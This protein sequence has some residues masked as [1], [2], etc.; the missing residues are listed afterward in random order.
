[1]DTLSLTDSSPEV[2]QCGSDR[3][4]YDRYHYSLRFYLTEFHCIRPWHD[5]GHNNDLVDLL[6]LID[7]YRN[8]HDRRRDKFSATT[9]F[10]K[11][12]R[13]PVST[14][15]AQKELQNNLY[16]FV[17]TVWPYRE[18]IKVV[19][20]TNWGYVYSN[21]LDLLKKIAALPGLANTRLQQMVIDRPLNTVGLRNKQH[22]YRTYLRDLRV[23]ETQRD[24][25]QQY[26]DQQQDVRLCPSLKSWSRVDQVYAWVKNVAWSRS[27]FFFDHQ[28]AADA[29]MLEM[30]VPGI[31]RKTLEI[32]EVNNSTN[33]TP[34]N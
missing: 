15:A 14:A 13:D 1:M 7:R 8:A 19:A 12:L 29:L 25:I 3:L 22:N 26:L 18:E 23:T 30:I 32:V 11:H 33:Y 5:A 2:D 27:T 34:G 17:E 21:N 10:P 24:Q 28:G 9:W 6:I 20:T 16:T 31:V 4:F